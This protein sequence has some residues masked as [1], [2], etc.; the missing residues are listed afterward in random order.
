MNGLKKYDVPVPRYTSYPTVP[1]WDSG[2]FDPEGYEKSLQASFWENSKE[3]SL[4]IHL[5]FCESLC[6]YCAC[7][8]RIT[9]NHMVEGP[10]IDAL[11]KEW[12][13]YL[14]K[15][16]TKPLIREIHL[17]GGTPTFFTA[18][19]LAK[20]LFKIM[21]GS[22]ISPNVSMSFEG[23]PANTT[24]EHL[25]VLRSLGFDRISLGI[26]DFDPHVQLLINRQQSFEHVKEITSKARKLGYTSINYDVVYG[27]PGQTQHS[28]YE[29]LSRVIELSPD[30]IAY[31]GY[32]HVPSM[33][34]A[35]KSYE[36]SLPGSEEK[37][38]FLEAGRNVFVNCGYQEVGLDHYVKSHD[39]LLAA[40][41][42][43]TLHRNFM[44]YT[45]LN[46]R[47]LIG[48]GMSAIG[49]A[50]TGFIQNTK[51][52]KH[53]YTLVNSD[54]LPYEKGH[55]LNA[56]DLFLRKQITRVM[57]EM[58]TQWS[59]EEIMEYGMNIDFHALEEMSLNGLIEYHP[60]GIKVTSL[61]KKYLRNICSAFDGR[62]NVRKKKA[63]VHSQS[64]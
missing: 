7:N 18:R 25:I 64:I 62:A 56:E 37:L 34:P 31:Y 49:D 9:T 40:K 24:T 46:S 26:Q 12:A 23:H 1:L 63:T 22:E 57:C 58:E 20:L 3:I 55:L 41:Q 45:S 5:P 47:L 32:A 59:D 36:H 35:Q 48:L 51:S 39:D 29:T 10:Y 33:R 8:T 17:G 19:N 50:W 38:T 4:Y 42:A 28:V 52:L 44:G 27:L 43:G 61:G 54:R 14:R 13:L 6:T 60:F 21:E 11:L 2:R 53:Y 15:F 16:P 30:R